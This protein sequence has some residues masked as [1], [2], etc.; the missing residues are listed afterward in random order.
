MLTGRLAA[1]VVVM[2]PLAAQ[3]DI[4]LDLRPGICESAELDCGYASP[5]VNLARAKSVKVSLFGYAP[6]GAINT[7]FLEYRTP[8]DPVWRKIASG[9]TIIVSSNPKCSAKL[10]RECT[11]TA[12]PTSPI[13]DAAK[14]QN[15]QVRLAYEEAGQDQHRPAILDRPIVQFIE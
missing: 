14:A 5:F 1:I 4:T 13:I 3:A 6:P 7:L 12:S 10:P 2:A 9:Q 15:V 8:A 11:P